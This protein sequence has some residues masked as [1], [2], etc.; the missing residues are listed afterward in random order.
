M[1]KLYQKLHTSPF[2]DSGAKVLKPDP[3]LEL[4]EVV[5]TQVA[6]HHCHNF[7]FTDGENLHFPLL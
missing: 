2:L 4:L 3:T 6:R 7:C 1:H 5:R